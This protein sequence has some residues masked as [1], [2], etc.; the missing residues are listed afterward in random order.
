VF[1]TQR[2]LLCFLSNEDVVTTMR[3]V[4][5]S[6]TLAQASRRIRQEAGSRRIVGPEEVSQQ[7]AFEARGHQ[8]TALTQDIRESESTVRNDC[9]TDSWSRQ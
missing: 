9:N 6:L 1:P 7:P 8:R 3:E 2:I 4:S 5:Q